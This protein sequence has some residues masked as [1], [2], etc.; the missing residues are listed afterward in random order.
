MKLTLLEQALDFDKSQYDEVEVGKK[1]R[2]FYENNVKGRPPQELFELT[3]Y[4]K[5]DMPSEFHDLIEL[6]LFRRLNGNL[7][8]E[9]FVQ[10]V[11]EHEQKIKEYV[12]NLAEDQSIPKMNRRSYYSEYTKKADLTPEL[13]QYSSEMFEREPMK[14]KTSLTKEEVS[15]ITKDGQLAYGHYGIPMRA[16]RVLIIAGDK[17]ITVNNEAIQE[18]FRIPYYKKLVELSGID[19]D[20]SKLPGFKDH[21]VRQSA[22][23][24]QKVSQTAIVPEFDEDDYVEY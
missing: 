12:E 11:K 4:H 3:L 15:S 1:L 2:E 9:R 24:S 5:N 14:V 10:A 19:I 22:G 17:K 16:K 23:I 20:L 8:D 7:N 18:S 21:S 6:E 13:L